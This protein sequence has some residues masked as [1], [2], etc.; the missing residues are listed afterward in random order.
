MFWIT[1]HLV[2]VFWKYSESENLWLC[3]FE[4]TQNQRTVDFGLFSRPQRT[5]SFHERTGK[6]LTVFSKCMWSVLKPFFLE[7]WGY[8]SEWVLRFFWTV[9]IQPWDPPWEPLV[10]SLHFLIAAQHWS[11]QKGK[12]FTLGHSQTRVNQPIGCLWP[13]T[14][15]VCF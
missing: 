3:F 5:C 6:E 1:E 4:K 9:V 13:N 15:L 10:I 12:N 14:Y 11:G 8:V 2:M 7:K